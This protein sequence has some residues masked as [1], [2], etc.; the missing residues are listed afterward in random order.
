MK[1]LKC[2][3]LEAGNGVGFEIFEFQDP[4]YKKPQEFEYNRGGFF[5]IAITV[6]DPSATAKK[7]KEFGGKQIG[8]AVKVFGEDA[9]YVADP[10]GNVIE[11]LSCSFTQL[12]GASIFQGI[13]PTDIRYRWLIEDEHDR[14]GD[15]E[16]P[17]I[18]RRFNLLLPIIRITP[19]K[20]PISSSPFQPSSSL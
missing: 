11:C 13:A 10:W 20:P 7:V 8:E 16:C 14:Q 5:H 12:V 18:V 2:A 17:S 1:K 4:P 3:Y 19:A 9:L 6:L 15:A